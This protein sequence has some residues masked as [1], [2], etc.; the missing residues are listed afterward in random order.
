MIWINRR[1]ATDR[2]ECCSG[3]EVLLDG[4]RW[5]WFPGEGRVPG[6]ATSRQEGCETKKMCQNIHQALRPQ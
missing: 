6:P 2:R 4:Q 3:M 1:T 5:R